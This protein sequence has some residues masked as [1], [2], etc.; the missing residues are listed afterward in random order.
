LIVRAINTAVFRL[1]LKNISLTLCNCCIS[2]LLLLLFNNTYSNANV[3]IRLNLRNV[4]QENINFTQPFYEL[5]SAFHRAL[6]QSTT[7]ISRL[8]TFNC[9]KLRG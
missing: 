8:N 9:T 3:F 2:L 7:F 5:I 6:L 4:F 1:D